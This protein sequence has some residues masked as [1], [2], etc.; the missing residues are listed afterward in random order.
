MV[1]VAALATFYG[2]YTRRL[3]KVPAVGPTQHQC[4]ASEQKTAV[5]N[6]TS[7]FPQ[8]KSNASVLLQ[9]PQCC[10]AWHAGFMPPVNSLHLHHGACS[11]WYYN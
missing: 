10:R 1:Y 8:S 11:T 5:E 3:R 4:H 2:Q 9:Q 6:R 7:F